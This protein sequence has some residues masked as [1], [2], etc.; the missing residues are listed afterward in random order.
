[1]GLFK[2]IGE[3]L[4]KT[5]NFLSEKIRKLVHSQWNEETFNELEQLLYEADIGSKIAEKFIQDLKIFLQNHPQANPEEI[6]DHM[7]SYASKLLQVVQKP[8]G[9]LNKP[10]VFLIVGVNGTGKTTSIAK[11]AYLWKKEGKTV[12]LGAADT[13]RAGAIHQLCLWAEKIGVDIVKSSP[14]SDPSSV[15][16]DTLTAG[17]SRNADIVLIDTAG[18]LQNKTDLMHELEKILRVCHKAIPGS[19]HET[20]LVLDA[21]TGQNSLEQ[22]QVF[23]QFTPLTGIIMSKLDGSAKGGVILP[24][25]DTLQIPVRWIG[26]GEKIEDLAPFNIDEYVDGLLDSSEVR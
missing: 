12:L 1:M 15:V 6:L 4:F 5:R 13:F 8:F 22:A 2:T 19:P 10:Q 17:K 26:T 24:I 3:A 14:H 21:T 7:K 18:R 20:L 11:L 25:V 23:D 9:S 16:F